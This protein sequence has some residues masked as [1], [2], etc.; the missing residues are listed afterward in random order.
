[1]LDATSSAPPSGTAAYTSR[2]T[3]ASNGMS[4]ASRQRVDRGRG[5]RC[6]AARHS[7]SHAD[8]ARRVPRARRRDREQRFG[9]DGQPFAGGAVRVE[10]ARVG[11][12]DDLLDRRVEPRGRDLARERRADAQRR[13]RDDAATAN[14]SVANERVVGRDRVRPVAQARERVGEQRPAERARERARRRPAD[15]GAPARDDEAALDRAQPGREV[16]DV[17]RREPAL[18]RSRLTVH[19]APSARPG[20]GDRGR[21]ATRAA[22]GTRGRDAPDPRAA[23]APRRRPALR[24]TATP[25]RPSVDRPA[26]A[27]RARRT[28]GPTVRRGGAD[29]WSGRRRCRAARADG[30]PCTRASARPRDRPRSRPDGSA[31]PRFPTCSTRRP[32]VPTAARARARRTRPSVRR[33]R[34]ARAAAPSRAS[35]KR[36]RRRPRARRDDRVGDAGPRP[37]V[38]ERGRERGAEVSRPSARLASGQNAGMTRVVLVPGFTQTA[39]AWDPVAARAARGGPRAGRARRARRPTTSSATAAAIGATGGRG[40]VRRLLD[41]RPAVPAARARPPRSRRAARARERVARASPTRPS[42]RRA[43][44]ATRSSRVDVEQRGVEPFLRDWLAQPLFAT[45]AR[46]R[47]R[48][49]R[50]RATAHTAAELAA[51]LRTLGTGTQEPLWDRLARAAD[52]DRARDRARRREVRRDQRRDGSRVHL[53]A[54]ARRACASTAVTRS[55]SSS[56]PRS[57]ACSSSG[58]HAE[59]RARRDGHRAISRPTASS[60]PSTSWN[61]AV[62]T[63]ARTSDGGSDRCRTIVTGSQRERRGRAARAA[64]TGARRRARP[65]KTSAPT[66]HATNI[67]AG[68]RRADAHGERALA[69]DRGRSRR[70]AGCSRAGSR[71]RASPT[72]NAASHA[73]AG[74]RFELHVD[75]AERRDDAEEAQHRDLAETRVAVGTRTT[76]VERGRGDRRDTD[77]QQPPVDRERQDEADDR[78]DTRTRSAR[79][80][81]P[82]AASRPRSR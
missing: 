33:S 80:C 66:R 38:D 55:R 36:E 77:E 71:P 18:R 30:W 54:A 82:R 16:G 72:A 79:R 20:V 17:G 23:R 81:A 37:L 57:R 39:A 8:S 10:P 73:G 11:I 68:P 74:T 44:R 40:R 13:D 64:P 9:V 52:A 1:M 34:R 67:D 42:A 35:G 7:A 29:R 50:S 3:R 63:S 5:P 19:G 24:S 32:G 65:S 45:L 53:G 28:S 69:R 59:I 61:R 58:S 14:D 22:R 70:R 62:A 49:R 76:G 2:A 43:A 15:A 31:R 27:G 26:R 51:T 4:S 6:S 48:S 21:R 47:G 41:G 46:R 56:R 12:D 25:R 75:R 78:R 60:A